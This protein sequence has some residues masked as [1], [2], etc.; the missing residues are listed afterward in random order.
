MTLA[1]ST[2][3]RLLKAKWQA[4]T[5]WPRRL[6]WLE[7]RGI[8][9]WVGQRIS[10]SFPIIAICGENGS[11]KSTI[12]QAAASLYRQPK[13]RKSRYK[14]ASDFLPDT[15]W[16][17]ITDAYIQGQIK[18]GD[19]HP[20]VTKITK[21]TERWRGNPERRERWVEYIDLSRTQP[22]SARTGY[23]RIAKANVQETSARELENPVRERLTGIM[24]RMYD[25]AKI[26]LTDADPKRSVSVV[27]LYGSSVSGFHQGAGEI[28][29]TELLEIS[30]QKYGLLLVDEIETS[31]H[32][33][34]QRRLIRDLA[35]LCRER[36]LQIILSTH[37]PY[38]L[39]EIP[40][41][42]RVYIMERAGRR[43]L[44]VGVSPDFAMSKMDD[45]THPEC[46]L[47]VEDLRARDLLREILV[48]CAPDEVE[49][50]R[51]IQYG[52][53]NVGYALG[54]MLSRK[55]FPIPSL[56]FVDGDKP[57]NVGCMQLP[58][59]D[60]PERVVFEGL[61]GRNWGSLAE[62]TG[63][64]YSPVADA[65]SR[66]MLAAD[67]KEWINSAASKLL[68]QGDV[69]W[70]LMCQEWA[71]RC[72]DE[73]AGKTIAKLLKD[74]LDNY[75][76]SSIPDVRDRVPNPEDLA[77]WPARPIFAAERPKN[78]HDKPEKIK[79][80]PS[81]QRSL[82]EVKEES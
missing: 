5:G 14:Y 41:E 29:V 80:S 19:N 15:P 39:A 4:A 38:I 42:G 78:L 45:E 23:S 33:R 26:A 25:K 31:L 47:Y 61:K 71:C 27:S 53:A 59:D 13:G 36:E 76:E 50:C 49:R 58:G 60:A 75:P 30:P 64:Q 69:L 9:G 2:E 34:A 63:R 73:S 62:R 28:T 18:E 52:A 66:A 56:V 43:E 70:S 68:M 40:P 67:H 57:A 12:L 17:L 81:P 44:M 8:R 74:A 11:G 10:F 46:D 22:V 32:P 65:C 51:F 48:V 7:I 24:G 37:S 21:R 77:P 3:M 82:F 6:E 20:P 1:T 79:D 72:L 35:D 16:D 54:Q 55:A